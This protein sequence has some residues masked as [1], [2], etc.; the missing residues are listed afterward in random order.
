MIRFF[1]PVLSLILSP[2]LFSQP[3]HAQSITSERQITIS[4]LRTELTLAAGTSNTGTLRLYN[5]GKQDLYIQMNTQLFTIA[6]S[7]YNYSFDENNAVNQWVRYSPANFSLEAGKSLDIQY[8]VNVPLSASVGDKYFMMFASTTPSQSAA[9]KTAE[10]VG[11]IVYLTVPGDITRTG[12]LLSLRSPLLATKDTTWSAN[13][14]N[15]GS[16]LFR[17]HYTVSVQTL[18]GQEVNKQEDSALILSNSIRLVSNN[19]EMPSWLGVYKVAY[20]FE[21]GDSNPITETHTLIYAPIP[22]VVLLLVLL[23]VITSPIIARY[24]RSSKKKKIEKKD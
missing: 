9:I 2:F 24:R 21:L 11:S 13:I 20:T 8:S 5:T 23:S 1:L 6:D 3:L 22:Q 12:K 4:P 17:S 14:Q 16:S 7:D 18:W 15:A 19:L 10:R